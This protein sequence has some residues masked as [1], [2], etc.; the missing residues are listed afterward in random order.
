[1]HSLPPPDS[2]RLRAAT[3][4]LELGC[5]KDAV[6]EL[7]AI[8]PSH[9]K[10][11]DVLELRWQLHAKALEWTA[12][13]N[14]ARTLVARAPERVTGWLHHAYALRRTPDGNVQL[15]FD[16]LLPAVDRFPDKAIVPYNLACYACQLD[17][18]AEALAWLDR[19]FKVGNKAELKRMARED[20]DLKSL[21]SN[22]EK[23]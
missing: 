23:L 13:A 22:I 9:Q 6:V 8:Q 3:G 1:M 2:H 7:D 5:P 16:A 14:A 17:R 12:A 11:P 4:W 21:W 20:E 18:P 19:A 15:A 10:H